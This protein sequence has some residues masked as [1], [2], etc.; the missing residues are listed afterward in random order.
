[1]TA[2]GALDTVL[3]IKSYKIY[4]EYPQPMTTG[5]RDRIVDLPVLVMRSSRSR[6][7]PPVNTPQRHGYM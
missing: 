6:S 4:I 2:M 1:M 7:I 3:N 5:P